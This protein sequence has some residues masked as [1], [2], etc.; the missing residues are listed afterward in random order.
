[1]FTW[2]FCLRQRKEIQNSDIL[3]H[4]STWEFRV[5]CGYRKTLSQ[6]L[7]IH[8][9]EGRVVSQ[10]WLDEAITDLKALDSTSYITTSG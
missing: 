9:W 4:L 1:M 7:L 8:I 6:I 10:K 2:T 3:Q 5:C